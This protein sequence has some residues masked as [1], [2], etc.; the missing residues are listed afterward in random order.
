LIAS[1]DGR[2]T[3]QT[4]SSTALMEETMNASDQQTA[5][6]SGD[7]DPTFGD[8]GI[9][10]LK[11]GDASMSSAR[12]VA[13]AP[14]G[15][16]YVAGHT[17]TS[18]YALARLNP[19]GTPDQTFANAGL[20]TGKFNNFTSA[21]SRIRIAAD[22]RLIM[23]GF[24]QYPG[25][26]HQSP[27]IACFSTSGQL[28]PAFG[29]GGYVILSTA[30]E[31]TG[32]PAT[33]EGAQ[34]NDA[35]AGASSPSQS[36]EK[37]LS[38]GLWVDVAIIFKNNSDGSPDTSFLSVGWDLV[39]F[40]PQWC[41]FQ[42]AAERSGKALAAG[43]YTHGSNGSDRRPFLMRYNVDG[44]RDTTFGTNG[45]LIIEPDKAQLSS[46]LIRDSGKII[47][48]GTTEQ[49]AG[50][51]MAI[52]FGRNEDGTP[53]TTF[54]G[55]SPV[56][57]SAGVDNRECGWSDGALIPGSDKLAVAGTAVGERGRA[58][59]GRFEADGSP[60]LSFGNGTGLVEFD[61]NR[62]TVTYGLEVQNDQKLLVCG[63]ATAS[64]LQQGYVARLMG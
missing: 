56:F 45:A 59:V 6:A 15:K 19:D 51:Q 49:F 17:G 48:V 11:F 61:L 55:G 47:A 31:D 58:L 64:S 26:T 24:I 46:L 54:N 43:F 18:E 36:D 25:L 7:L 1:Q 42:A 44:T 38:T 16:I 39:N 20:A 53:D 27:V 14:D 35:D 62:N 2:R 33:G 34:L 50:P 4:R 41:S 40:K 22:G 60:D 63:M 8:A 29:S 23:H 32:S 28:D 52:L 21:G 13:L 9:A 10:S 37:I 12:G 57:T 30:A 3:L 5:L